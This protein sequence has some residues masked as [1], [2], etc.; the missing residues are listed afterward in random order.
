MESLIDHINTVDH[1]MKFTCEDVGDHAL[2]FLD[3]VLHIETGRSLNTEVYRACTQTSLCWQ[4]LCYIKVLKKPKN[5]LTRLSMDLENSR[6]VSSFWLPS[7]SALGIIQ[8]LN[9]QAQLLPPRDDRK[10]KNHIKKSLKR[11][12]DPGWAFLKYMKKEQEQSGKRWNREALSFHGRY[13]RKT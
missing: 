11:C 4:K 1:N 3:Y 8:I 10:E 13:I 7:S 12:G 2:A 6:S 9:H 5:N